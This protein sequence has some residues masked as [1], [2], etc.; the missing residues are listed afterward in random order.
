M[1]VGEVVMEEAIS[2][3]SN[4]L[5]CARAEYL[6]SEHGSHLRLIATCA[7]SPEALLR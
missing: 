4:T 6:F 5:R 1:K 2:G 7:P 3:G